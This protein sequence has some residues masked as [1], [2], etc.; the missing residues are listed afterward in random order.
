MSVSVSK[1]YREDVLYSTLQ[2]SLSIMLSY[3]HDVG[4]SGYKIGIGSGFLLSI[5]GKT[6]LI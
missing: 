4:R 3:G 1:G 5:T 6:Y 2:G